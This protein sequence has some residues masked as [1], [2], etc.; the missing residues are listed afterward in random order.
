M[1]VQVNNE[2]LA[3]GLKKITFNSSS[4][5]ILLHLEDFLFEINQPVKVKGIEISNEIEKIYN[6][7]FGVKNIFK[8]TQKELIWCYIVKHLYEYGFN[9]SDIKILRKNLSLRSCNKIG[10][11]V[12]LEYA[13]FYTLKTK[14]K[15]YFCI[16]KNG[17]IKFIDATENDTVFDSDESCNVQILLYK[18]LT[19]I[20]KNFEIKRKDSLLL[21]KG[22]V[23]L[24]NLLRENFDITDIKLKINTGKLITADVYEKKPLHKKYIDLLNEK[25]Y[26]TLTVKKENNRISFIQTNYRHFFN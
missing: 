25:D 24:I 9:E 21:Q 15:T 16:N 14:H 1:N 26:Q 13:I 11:L 3:D 17:C 10:D 22:E 2:H 12:L 4:R 23:E 19:R 5:S 20:D 6:D 8:A 7:E 18:Y